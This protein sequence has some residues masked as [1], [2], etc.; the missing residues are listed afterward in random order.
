MGGGGG[1]GRGV[2]GQRVKESREN[3]P[4]CHL[5]FS[6]CLLAYILYLMHLFCMGFLLVK[7]LY[8][9]VWKPAGT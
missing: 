5:L 4:I 3:W 2:S 9:L 1:G 6:A 7:R 8:V